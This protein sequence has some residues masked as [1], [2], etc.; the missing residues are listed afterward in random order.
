[1]VNILI[2]NPSVNM[3]LAAME[4]KMYGANVKFAYSS[5]IPESPPPPHPSGSQNRTSSPR[6]GP[7]SRGFFHA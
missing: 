3:R 1:M 4:M 7:G 5:D 6:C 2:V